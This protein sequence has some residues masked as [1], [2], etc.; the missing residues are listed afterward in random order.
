MADEREDD[1]DLSPPDSPEK[2]PYGDPE[3]EARFNDEAM[4]QQAQSEGPEQTPE[5]EA[6]QPD[7]GVEAPEEQSGDPFEIPHAEDF[8]PE[9]PEPPDG[10]PGTDFG[11]TEEPID[12]EQIYAGDTLT[13]FLQSVNDAQNSGED[14]TDSAKQ[15]LGMDKD[16]NLPDVFNKMLGATQDLNGTMRDMLLDHEQATSETLRMLESGRF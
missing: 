3:M 5:A 12:K 15:F 4:A 6:Q 8:V 16:Q 9:A 13:G 14:A 11:V 7:E 1:D 2:E 10:V